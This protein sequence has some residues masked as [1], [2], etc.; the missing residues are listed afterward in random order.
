M[1]GKWLILLWRWGTEMDRILLVI[2]ASSDMGL[3]TIDKIKDNYSCI[4]AHYF[5]MNDKLHNLKNN[6]GDKLILIQ[7]DL[8]NIDNVNNLI[9]YIK[10]AGIVPSH[11]IHFPAPICNNQKFHKIKWEVYQ[12]EIDISLKSLVIILQA[13][14]PYMV[15]N[16]Y[17]KILVMLS[18]VVANSAPAYCSNYVVTKYAML[19]LVKALATEYASKGI[20]VNGVSPSWVETKYIDNQPDILKERNAQESPIGRILAVGDVVPTIEYLLSEG[21]DCINGQNILVTCG[22]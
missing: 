3:A 1:S 16:H 14:L 17:G 4:I 20:T 21:A 9:D 18:F 6:L 7:A 19:G 2:G 10:E 12:N 22:R 8:A 13:F 5:H 15:R 11:I